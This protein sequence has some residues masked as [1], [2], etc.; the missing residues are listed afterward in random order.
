MADADAKRK[1]KRKGGTQKGGSAK[2]AKLCEGAATAA[3]QVRIG[4]WASF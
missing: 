4:R 3:T 1:G 2:K